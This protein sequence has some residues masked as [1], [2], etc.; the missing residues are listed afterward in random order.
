MAHTYATDS[1]E[2][3]QIPFFLAAVAIGLTFAVT[4][5]FHA[6][7]IELPWWSPPID[8]MAFYGM[9]YALFD[10]FIWKFRP[11][12]S[13]G[14]VRV[15]NLSGTW[16][17]DVRPSSTTGTSAGLGAPTTITLTIYQSWR[18]LMVKAQTGQS[19]S[20]S[21]SGAIVV[22][23]EPSLTYEF[24]NEPGAPAAPTMHTHRGVARLTLSQ[25]G[26]ELDGEY[27]SGRDRQNFGKMRVTRS[28]S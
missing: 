22:A 27:Y 21:L 9:L 28:A 4:R 1:D 24:L 16:R 20:H 17:G 12:R 15:P 3:K 14:L 6:R 13:I 25:D 8:T 26:T 18:E 19:K 5:F 23:D 2:R 7:H 11:L 10:R